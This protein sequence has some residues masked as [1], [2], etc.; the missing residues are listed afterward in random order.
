MIKFKYFSSKNGEVET[1]INIECDNFEELQEMINK[2]ENKL[3]EN[4]DTYCED[5][6][7][8]NCKMCCDCDEDYLDNEDEDFTVEDL[9]S[10]VLI[11]K[12]DNCKNMQE[13]IKV[14]KELYDIGFDDGYNKAIQDDVEEKM[15]YLNGDFEE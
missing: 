14:L 4:D 5:Y 10:Y 3:T 11:N 12:L 15:D 9:C 7:C 13:E 8:G 1:D 6:E 2:S